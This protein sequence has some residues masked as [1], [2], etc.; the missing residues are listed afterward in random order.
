MHIL[1]ESY[2]SKKKGK[3]TKKIANIEKVSYRE[4]Q[5]EKVR[6]LTEE[7]R[8]LRKQVKTPGLVFPKFTLQGEWFEE[9]D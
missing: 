9:A 2:A 1:K 3:R 7:I 8:V 5:E 6:I 4:E